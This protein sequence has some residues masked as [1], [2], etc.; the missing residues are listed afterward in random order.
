M[1]PSETNKM[2]LQS[3]ATHR[4]STNTSRNGDFD[5]LGSIKTVD[6]SRREKIRRALRAAQD[7][8]EYSDAGCGE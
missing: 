5:T 1:A 6:T 2:T 7:L 3:H 4:S 8:E